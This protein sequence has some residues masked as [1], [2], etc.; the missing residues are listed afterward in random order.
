MC[1]NFETK[2]QYK[3]VINDDLSQV[4]GYFYLLN[5]CGDFKPLAVRFFI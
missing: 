1:Y 3:Q 5:D 4:I 2:K